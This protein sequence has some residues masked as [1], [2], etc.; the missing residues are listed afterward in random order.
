MLKKTVKYT[1]FDGNQREEDLYFNLTQSELTEIQLGTAGGF[2]KYIKRI[3]QQQNTE[4]MLAFYTMLITKSYGVKSDDGK[5]FRKS[6]EALEDFKSTN[7]YDVIFNELADTEKFTEFFL[8]VIPAEAA[9]SIKT[10]MAK[11]EFNLPS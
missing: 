3:A 11:G 4:E 10:A 9:N 7:A 1:D 6:K 8:G 5:Y 2:D